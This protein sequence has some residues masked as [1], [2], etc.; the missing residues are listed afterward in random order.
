MAILPD[1]QSAGASPELARPRS[2]R[3]ALLILALAAIA[4]ALV[5][6]A[7]GDPRWSRDAASIVWPAASLNVVSGQAQLDEGRMIVRQ[8]GRKRVDLGT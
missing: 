7:A 3:T 5:F 8:S 2:A 6:L 4:V 1:V